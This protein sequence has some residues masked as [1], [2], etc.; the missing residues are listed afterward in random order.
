VQAATAIVLGLPTLTFA[1][2]A[3]VAAIRSAEATERQSIAADAQAKAAEAQ[4]AVTAKQTEILEATL[5]EQVRPFLEVESLYADKV[6]NDPEQLFL[7]RNQGSG[8]AKGLTYKFFAEDGLS[9][10]WLTEYASL[11]VPPRGKAVLPAKPRKF[12]RVQIYYQSIRD[13]WYLTVFANDVSQPPG[14]YL[15][16]VPPTPDEHIFT[17]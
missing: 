9:L 4:I 13:E 2:F 15:P 16:C 12:W 11:H 5:H 8:V 10:G 14:V 17:P 7:I 1:I 3:S 6:W